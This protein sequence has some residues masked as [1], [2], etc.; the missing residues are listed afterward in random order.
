MSFPIKNGGS[1]HSYVSLP[2]GTDFG[3]LPS[4]AMQQKPQTTWQ[5]KKPSNSE[6]RGDFVRAGCEPRPARRFFGGDLGRWLQ[7]PNCL[8]KKQ[9]KSVEHGDW[10]VVLT[11][12]TILKNMSS[13]M[14]RTITYIYI[15][16]YIME[17]KKCSKP[18]TS[19]IIQQLWNIGRLPSERVTK[20]I[21][22]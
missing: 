16:T 20:A 9:Q 22:T 7:P 11:C 17:N 6:L 10:L 19:W 18:L 8:G 2:E 12:L 14:G 13:S 15:Y 1:F 3:C 5:P 21:K 4:H